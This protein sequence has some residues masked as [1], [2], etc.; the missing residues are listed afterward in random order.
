MMWLSETKALIFTFVGMT[1]LTVIV[2]LILGAVQASG[3]A[4]GL[5]LVFLAGLGGFL[6]SLVVMHHTPPEQRPKKPRS[7]S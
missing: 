7:T 6:L 3:T 1:V 2:G 5:A 4:W